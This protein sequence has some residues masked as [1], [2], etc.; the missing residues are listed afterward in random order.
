[1]DNINTIN[2]KLDNKYIDK[3]YYTILLSLFLLIVIIIFKET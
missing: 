2:N 1:M 3:K